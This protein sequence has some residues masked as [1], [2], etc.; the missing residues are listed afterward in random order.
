MFGDL[1]NTRCTKKT[2][3]SRGLFEARVKKI[4]LLPSTIIFLRIFKWVNSFV[5]SNLDSRRKDFDAKYSER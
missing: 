3:L 5:S 2:T 4:A 1:V